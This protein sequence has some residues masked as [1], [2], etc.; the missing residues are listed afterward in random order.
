MNLVLYLL[1]ISKSRCKMFNTFI[2]S[3]DDSVLELAIEKKIK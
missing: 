1:Y 2:F 3:S